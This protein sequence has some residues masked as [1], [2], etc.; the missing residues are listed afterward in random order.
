MHG[1][2]VWQNMVWKKEKKRKFIHRTSIPVRTYHFSLPHDESSCLG[3]PCICAMGRPGFQQYWWPSS[4]VNGNMKSLSPCTT[5]VPATLDTWLMSQLWSSGIV[6][7]EAEWHI[8]QH[9]HLF[10]RS[11]LC[12]TCS[13]I[14]IYPG[15]WYLNS[16]QKVHLIPLAQI[17]LLH[18]LQ[19]SPFSHLKHPWNPLA[20]IPESV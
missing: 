8:G 2:W 18:I 4:F 1:W 16:F 20:T 15:C 14:S 17:F 13:F 6:E 10:T 5:S 7:E 19:T 11:L 12:N 9:C 3:G